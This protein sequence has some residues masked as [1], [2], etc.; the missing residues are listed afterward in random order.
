MLGNPGASAASAG[1][2]A[3]QVDQMRAQT[4]LIKSQTETQIA[5]RGYIEAQTHQA[6]ASAGQAEAS[7]DQI[8]QRMS[9]FEDEWRKL[10]YE[11]ERAGWEGRTAQFNA[12]IANTQDF[13]YARTL[14]SRVEA[15]RQ[16]ALKLREQARLL[17]LEIPGAVNDASFE[18]SS[19]GQGIRS[20][21]RG[22]GV[23]GKVFSSAGAARR[24]FRGDY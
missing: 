6:T 13:Y 12:G 20:A 3:A 5:Q 7:E 22:V 23:A 18:E 1:A 19:M 4:D 16:E 9:L 10:R 21:E 15:A 17:H 14:E 24:A 11:V 8:R 2:A